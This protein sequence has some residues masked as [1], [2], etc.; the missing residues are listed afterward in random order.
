MKTG[1]REAIANLGVTGLEAASLGVGLITQMLLMRALGPATFGVCALALALGALAGTVADFGFNFA[2]VRHA[3]QLRHDTDAAR[4]HYWCVQSC[5]ASVAMLLVT[6]AVLGVWHK[7][8][9]TPIA[10]AVSVSALTYVLFPAWYLLARSRLLAYAG[11]LFLGRMLA[12][13]IVWAMVKS[14]RDLYLGIAVVSG[15]PL[16]AAVLTLWLRD[17]RA[18]FP[19]TRLR[20][21]DWKTCMAEGAR[22]LPIAGLPFVAGA[23]VPTLIAGL[24]SAQVLG[25]YTAA[26][27][28]RLGIQGLFAAF[29][30]AAFPQT[31]SC[32]PAQWHRR[33]V[34]FA[35]ANV[36]VACCFAGVLAGTSDWVMATISGTA[37][38]DSASILRILA[39]A[40]VTSTAS[41]ALGLQALTSLGRAGQYS[42]AMAVGLAVQVGALLVAV[43]I[44]GAVGAAWCVIVGDIALL[45]LV[46]PL[47]RRAW[48]LLKT[49]AAGA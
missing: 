27:K 21:S 34:R 37:Y 45:M 3:V 15:S 4:R 20:V 38:S 33:I 18:L 36:G 49:R 19:P 40:I 31:S 32:S 42:M 47:T 5:K 30:Q 24:A 28:V 9:W 43:P 14:P 11:L 23:I 7:P 12:M 6:L 17:A 13:M 29:G 1:G 2:G 44:H 41:S 46:W 10:L 39:L 35:V 16:V 26:D 8:N 25:L 48:S 22:A